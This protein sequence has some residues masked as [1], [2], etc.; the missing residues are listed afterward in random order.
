MEAVSWLAALSARCTSRRVSMVL[1]FPE[2]FGGHV[3]GGPA[4]PRSSREFQDLESACYVR[5]GS[6]FLCQLASTDLRRSSRNFHESADAAKQALYTGPSWKDAAPNSSLKGPLPESCPC[7]PEHTPFRGTDAQEHFVFSSSQSPGTVFWEDCVADL[8]MDSFCSL[9]D[10]GSIPS[11][12]RKQRPHSHILI[13][14]VFSLQGSSLFSLVG[15][16]YVA[17][18]A[19]R[20]REPWTGRSCFLWLPCVAQPWWSSFTS[21][22]RV[23][24]IFALP[25]AVLHAYIAVFAGNLSSSAAVF[26]SGYGPFASTVRQVTLPFSLCSFMD[27]LTWFFEMSP[28]PHE[29]EGL[30][31]FRS[32][33]WFLVGWCERRSG[34]HQGFFNVPAVS[35]VR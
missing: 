20:L 35:V 11:Q 26:V 10:G 8:D 7:V 31:L 13:L 1:I 4:T 32:S 30:W 19:Q 24:G 23:T 22:L 16:Y 5:R 17:G 9:T 12:C 27:I 14:F 18:F 2:D 29:A 3:R 34:A 28:G 15:L 21:S 33:C 25:L 6:A